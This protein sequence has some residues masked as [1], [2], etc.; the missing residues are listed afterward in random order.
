MFYG[1]YKNK[2]QDIAESEL[3]R[4]S[5]WSIVLKGYLV[6]MTNPKSIAY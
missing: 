3:D 1:A 2:Y 6:N 4:Q 5:D